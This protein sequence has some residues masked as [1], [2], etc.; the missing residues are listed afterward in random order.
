V[1]DSTNGIKSAKAAGMFVAVVPRPD[2]PPAPDALDRA[3]AVLESLAD[4]PAVL[5]HVALAN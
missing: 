3:D 4:V 1:E 2:F 5:A